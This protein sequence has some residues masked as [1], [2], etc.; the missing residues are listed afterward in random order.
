MNVLVVCEGNT[1]AT[2]LGFYLERKRDVEFKP[3]SK[4]SFFNINLDS[5]QKQ[6]N[7]ATND[8]SIEIISVGGKAKIKKFLEEVKEYLINIRNENGLIDKLVVIVDRDDDTEESIRNLLGPF[9]TQ[10]VNQ[11]EEIS[12]NNVLFGELKIK[13]LLLCVPPDKPGALERF[14][15]DSLKKMKVV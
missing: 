1:D 6:I 2:L 12:L 4:K 5:Y 9:R 7:L 14:L 10:K 3:K 8:V 11:W 13:T 15:I